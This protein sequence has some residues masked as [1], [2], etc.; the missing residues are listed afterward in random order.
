MLLK[1]IVSV[2]VVCESELV[3]C[4]SLVANQM[5][6]VHSFFATGHCVVLLLSFLSTALSLI[7]DAVLQAN[8]IKNI[9]T[10]LLFFCACSCV[11]HVLYSVVDIKIYHLTCRL[12]T[13]S[14]WQIC[15]ATPLHG[16]SQQFD[17]GCSFALTSSFCQFLF[18]I[19]GSYNHFEC[20]HVSS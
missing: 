11:V 2:A 4:T 9:P 14:T 18:M 20:L 16:N 5:S 19:I 3:Y 7:K 10:A 12:E 1:K 6:V 13:V 17:L 15:S 8:T